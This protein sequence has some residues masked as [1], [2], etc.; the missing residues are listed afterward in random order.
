MGITKEKQKRIT[1]ASLV[2][3]VDVQ[4]TLLSLKI[5][6]PT[7]IKNREIK[8]CSLR[9]ANRILKAKGYSFILSEA[10]RIDDVIV[11]RIK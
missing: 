3:R 2:K 4:A 10:G 1:S 11:T 7:S 8:A 5:G 6:V 9:S